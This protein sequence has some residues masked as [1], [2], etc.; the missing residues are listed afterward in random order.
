M[1]LPY[2][3]QPSTRGRLTT[4]AGIVLFLHA[5][6]SAYEV[7]SQGKSIDLSTS[8]TAYESNVPLDIK[9]ETLVAF[10]VL[11]VGCAMTTPKLRQMTWTA[12]MRETDIDLVDARP[13]FATV[14]HRGAKLFAA[15]D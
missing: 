10:V 13:S 8:T 5:A 1:L 12:R 3:E 15:R 9:F 7:L 14:Y 4:I 11:V 6:Y 2:R